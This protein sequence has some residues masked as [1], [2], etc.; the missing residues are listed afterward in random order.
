M[1]NHASD[2]S[3]TQITFDTDCT[4]MITADTSGRLKLWDISKVKWRQ[5]EEEVKNKDANKVDDLSLISAMR[6]IWFI[7][8]HKSLVNSLAIVETYSAVSDCFVL[9]AGN[10]CNILLHRLS[11][12]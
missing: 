9:S 1:A 2:D 12:G 5:T 8:A 6:D 11:N 4:R 3:L 7:Q 10:D